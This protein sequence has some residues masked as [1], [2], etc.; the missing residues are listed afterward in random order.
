MASL[1]LPFQVEAPGVSETLK[2]GQGA[3]VSVVELARRKALAVSERRPGAWVLGADQLVSLDGV[4]LGKPADRAAAR[5]QLIRL[6]GRSH[7]IIT[8]LCLTDG[9]RRWETLE[10]TQVT[11]YPLLPAE[12]E[13]YLDTG[14]WQGCAGGY[15]VE[16]RGQALMAQ[17]AGDRTNVQGLPLPL[18]VR[19]LRE[20]GLLP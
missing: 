20:A 9:A 2:A 4:P 1:G 6:A 14:E 16:G 18:V 12:L 8:G 11:L 3:L 7:E 15:R 19:L 10:M 17:V 13:K 5:E